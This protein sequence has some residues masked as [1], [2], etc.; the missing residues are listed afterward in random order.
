MIFTGS[1]D[2]VKGAIDGSVVG[3]W[4]GSMYVGVGFK[5]LLLMTA[6]CEAS[7]SN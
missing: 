6:D 3:M 5:G 1:V 4:N 2:K 7:I